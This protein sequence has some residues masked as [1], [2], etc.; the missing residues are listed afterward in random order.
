MRKDKKKVLMYIGNLY[1]FDQFY[2]L[3]IR[4][5]SIK[6]KQIYLLIEKIIS[7]KFLYQK[8]MK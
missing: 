5:L 3:I 1:N 8:L 2:S 6:N 4:D 7:I